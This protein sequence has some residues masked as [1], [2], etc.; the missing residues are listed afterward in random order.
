M[1]TVDDESNQIKIQNRNDNLKISFLSVMV[2]SHCSQFKLVPN[3][4]KKEKK[5]K[6]FKG[7]IAIKYIKYLNIILYN[8]KLGSN[9]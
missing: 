6:E 1:A 9:L 2:V 3:L 4:K 8:K 7:N 5:L